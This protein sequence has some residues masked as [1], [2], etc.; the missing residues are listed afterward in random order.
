MVHK[1]GFD[2][3]LKFFKVLIHE[4]GKTLIKTFYFSIYHKYLLKFEINNSKKQFKTLNPLILPIIFFP[5]IQFKYNY[6]NNFQ[7]NDY[8]T[9]FIEILHQL[10]NY[11]NFQMS[12]FIFL[13]FFNLYFIKLNLKFGFFWYYIIYIVF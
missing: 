3:Y 1:F 5:Y 13:F 11:L 2:S 10:I 6:H 7:F 12:M 4:N 8:L 9:I